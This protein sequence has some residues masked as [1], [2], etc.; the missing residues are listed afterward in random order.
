[1]KRVLAILFLLIFAVSVTASP[2]AHGIL[3]WP[4]GPCEIH[5]RVGSTLMGVCQDQVYDLS[6]AET[7]RIV[8]QMITLLAIVAFVAV[9]LP[10]W[11]KSS[12]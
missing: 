11:R 12:H 7:Q 8:L 6:S 2:I 9:S 3:S 1:M 5:W 10:A 4:A